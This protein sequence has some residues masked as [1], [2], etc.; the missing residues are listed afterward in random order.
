MMKSPSL[1]LRRALTIS[2]PHHR[3]LLYTDGVIPAEEAETGQWSNTSIDPLPHQQQQINLSTLSS[4]SDSNRGDGTSLG[5]ETNPD[6][7]LDLSMMMRYPSARDLTSDMPRFDPIAQTQT[8]GL[9]HP[10]HLP[11]SA[12]DDTANITAAAAAASLYPNTFENHPETVPPGI[13]S[14]LDFDTPNPYGS[15]SHHHHQHHQHDSRRAN[16]VASHA[17]HIHNHTHDPSN[18]KLE[19]EHQLHDMMIDPNLRLS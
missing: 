5:T 4:S 1:Y 19:D 18:M 2:E 7:I 9:Q 16:D 10:Q 11:V 13:V 3:D 8:Q 12:T 6:P 14:S 15:L 17:S